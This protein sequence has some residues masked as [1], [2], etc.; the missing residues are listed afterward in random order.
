MRRPSSNMTPCRAIGGCCAA[1]ACSDYVPDAV[2]E[3]AARPAPGCGGRCPRVV[4]VALDA[5]TFDNVTAV[6][7]DVDARASPMRADSRQPVF[8]GAAAARFSEDLETA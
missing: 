7:C 6:V 4:H 5:G 8:H 1:T 3:A 2:I